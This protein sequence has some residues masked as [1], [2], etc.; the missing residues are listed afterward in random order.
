MERAVMRRGLAA[1]ALVVAV[2]TI[3]TG[4][5]QGA[6]FASG[7][8]AVEQALLLQPAGDRARNVILFVGDGMGVSTVTAARILEGQLR[9][10][11]G[12]EHVLAFE[13]LPYLALSKTYSVN[14][15][16]SDSAP[17]ATAMM[18]G[19]KTNDA[20]I[21]LDEGAVRAQHATAAGREL[22]T[23]LELAEDAGLGTGIVTTARLT[24]ATPAAAYAHTVERDWEDDATL[25][26]AARRDG[27][28]DIA[29]QFVQFSRG[30]GIEVALG[31]GRSQFL[32][33]TTVDPEYPR[34]SGN[35]RDG[36]NLIE[37]WSARSRHGAF[38]WNKAGF[39]EVDP[40]RVERLL[41]LFEPSHMQYEHDRPRDGAGEPSL[42]EMT[43]KALDILARNPRGYFLL[44]E[45]GRI[46][47]AHHAGNAYRALTEAIELSNAVRL[48]R[49]RTNPADTLIIVTADHSHTLTVAGNATRGNP[50]LGP[51]I[52]NDVHGKPTG[53]LEVDLL[54]RAYTTL[55]YR[56]GQGYFEA[57][58]R[59]DVAFTD[60]ADPNYRQDALT[61]LV[62]ETHAGEDV[63]IYAG[64]P[65][66]QLFHGVLEQ[67]VI[68]HVMAHALRLAR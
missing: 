19:V 62:Q 50:I 25:A 67:H 1:A 63:A 35:R 54:G 66:A 58:R 22:T 28:A 12:E 48:A 10:E 16:V 47:H 23:L 55:G 53:E 6:W 32:P 21:G 17:T 56:N 37:E 9:G 33:R 49:A 3:E 51:V 61:P 30:D 5:D 42:T 45:G 26:P 18:T 64:G 40:A 60:T 14:Q 2:S 29:K 39:D 38:V 44:V 8:A 65:A 27:F 36:R 57:R 15:Q 41:G 13:R 11:P 20:V 52:D 59:F 4:A 46:D 31:G 24:H 68:F 34:F 7:R 43:A